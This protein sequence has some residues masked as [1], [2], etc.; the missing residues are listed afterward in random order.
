MDWLD[1][2]ATI[3]D[4]DLHAFARDGHVTLRGLLPARDLDATGRE[5]TRL[6]LG[7]NTEQR[8]LDER[9][10]YGRAFLQ[11]MNLWEKSPLVGRFVMGQ[12]LARVAAQLLGVRGVRLYHDQSLYKEPNGGHTPAHA[13]QYYWPLASDRTIT[14]WIPLQDV[15]MAMGPLGFYSGSHRVPEGRDLG[16]S[17]ASEDDIPA[18]MA[19]LGH[20]YVCSP[21]ALG[22]VSFHLGWTFHRAEPNTSDRPRSVIT[23][24]F[25]ADDTRLLDVLNPIQQNDRDQWCPGVA[26]GALVDSRK[27]PVIWSAA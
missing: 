26:T 22:D 1:E 20:P 14:A 7:L 25:M 13:D 5:I 8:V 6:T 21:F 2:P 19:A 3:S 18:R 27:N 12:R 4:H 15:P 23:V 9:D 11:V 10:T 17:D 24:I 16:I